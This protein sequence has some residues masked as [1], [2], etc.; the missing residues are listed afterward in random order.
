MKK[1]IVAN[2]KMNPQSLAE[3]K[4]IFEDVKKSLKPEASKKAEV[5]ICPPSLYI[6]NLKSQI[7]NLKLGAQDCFWEEKGAFTGEISPLML[8]N[9]GVKYVILG[10]SERRENLGETNEVVNLKV[11]AALK[12]NLKVILCVGEKTRNDD[13]FFNIIKEE[14]LEG[15][16]NIPKTSAKNIIVAYEP[17]WAI[18]A[19]G[20]KA[21][22]PEDI[23]E[24]AI[25]IR[26]ILFDIF[27]KDAAYSIPVLYGGSVNGKN[28]KRFLE[29]EGIAGF[30]VG[31][32]SLDPGDFL[33]IA[34]LCPL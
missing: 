25:Y 34:N 28:A 12:K 10:H 21:D 5:V 23:F 6:S 4:R 1:L 31:Q 19:G 27:G 20:G 9:L 17:I 16:K 7:S 18:S 26:K 24:M 32:A 33:K 29:I 14:L 2:W 30:L 3:A 13:D 15:L 22:K 11:G 8:K